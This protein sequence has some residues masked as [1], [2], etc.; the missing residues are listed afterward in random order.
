MDSPFFS[1]L[2]TR[3][4]SGIAL[5]VVLATGAAA[6]P[7]SFLT[8]NIVTTAG[9]TSVTFGGQTFVNQ[10]LQGAARLD[11]TTTKDFNGDTFGAFSSLDILPGTWRKT[12]SGGYTGV[13]YSLP[14]RG[15]NGI[16][17][18]TFSNY[19]GR[20][21]TFNMAFTPYTG[22]ADLPATASSNQQ[23]QLTQTGGFFFKDF[24][25]NVATGL[26]PLQPGSTQQF[27]TQKGINLPGSPV[28]AAAGK[29]SLDAEGLRFLQ[30]GTFYVSDEY[31]ANV[32]Y[33][34]KT[35]NMQGVILP[36]AALIP[37]D[38]AGNLAYNSIT[39]SATGRRFNQGI[40]GMAV[41]PDQKKLVTILQSATE[42]DSTTANQATRT[43]TRLMIYDI[44]TTKTP[45]T[46]IADHVLQLPIW[47]SAGNG[48]AANRTAA[49][50]EVLALNDTQF[51]VLSR[52]SDGLGTANNPLVF[53]SV[54]LVDTT[55]ATNIAGTTF[56]TANVPIS[57][58]GALV[59]TITPVRQAE[60]LNILNSTQLN[61][62]G[63]NLNNATPT[64]M[65]L[66][67]KWEGMAL[68][69]VLEENA[70]QDFFLLIGNDND[71]LSS[72]CS[73]G[74]QN[75]AQAVNSDG[76]ILV[77]RMTLPTYVDP[78][79]L[80]A[81]TT[82]GPLAVEMTGQT[83]LAIA[84]TNSPN[85]LSQLNAQRRAGAQQL[86]FNGWV[87][88]SYESSKWDNFGRTLGLNANR[89]GF[90]GTV[91]FDYS[92]LQGLMV[93]VAAGYGDISTDSKSGFNIS[94]HGYSFSVYARAMMGGLYTQAGYSLGH[95]DYDKILRPSAY[96]LTGLGKTSGKTE[97][98]FVEAGYMFDAGDNV[99]IGPLV[100]YSRDWA[101]INGYTE[102]GAAGGNIIMPQNALSTSVVSIGGEIS[103]NFDGYLPYARITYN[104]DFST[105]PRSLV[106]SLASAQN[107]MGTQTVTIPAANESYTEIGVGIQGVVMERATWN[108][109]Y[110]AQIGSDDR[111][112]HVI[113]AGFGYSF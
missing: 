38:A 43:N 8:P 26:D 19:A 42:Q 58:G 112:S 100:G 7:L 9:S 110:G 2:K 13:L 97:S 34:D 25:G 1:H 37:R 89:D 96:G 93:G 63:I 72:T 81:L 4:V 101:R 49:Q 84:A 27:V 56:E 32:Y 5:S 15:P 107:A 76:V 55:G 10:G 105:A 90:R 53:K 36:P 92:F 85:I 24:N 62:F 80:A 83:G 106:L 45:T 91:G 47:N 71:F 52:D 16:G 102:T 29:I 86:G 99:K 74:G 48:G 68:V 57:P 59:S 22:T 98:A 41:T 109:G 77:Y 3:L 44:S 21:S 73:V 39:D 103:G 94:A 88:G 6:A 12:A 67:E 46:P 54:L 30:D 60:V 64:R 82:T 104:H 70:P 11:A 17:Q 75:C 108:L 95:A 79:Y 69:P 18:V 40:E 14:D 111:F 51:L 78:E 23:L 50:S 66:T 28:G 87:A 113:H 20:V 35:G 61:K 33:F 31:G 65:T